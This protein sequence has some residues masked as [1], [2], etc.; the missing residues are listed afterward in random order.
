MVKMAKIEA[1]LGAART[2]TMRR[3]MH[4]LEKDRQPPEKMFIFGKSFIKELRPSAFPPTGFHIETITQLISLLYRRVQKVEQ[5]EPYH[6]DRYQ[7]NH[8]KKCN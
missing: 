1:I 4:N 5:I 2:R 6:C 7:N 3:T 8:T